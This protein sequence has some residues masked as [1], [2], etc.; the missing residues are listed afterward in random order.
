M[1]QCF[2]D[3]YTS[4]EITYIY[5]L[6]VNDI[7]IDPFHNDFSHSNEHSEQRKLAHMS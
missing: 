7:E 2:W 6:I 3:M 5:S 4:G 1:N